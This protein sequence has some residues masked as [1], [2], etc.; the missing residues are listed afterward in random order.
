MAETSVSIV[1]GDEAIKGLRAVGSRTVRQKLALKVDDLSKANAPEQIGKPLQDEL[2]GLFRITFGRYRTI[3]S[4]RRSPTARALE[5]IVQV[6]LVGIRK[7]G[8]K[9]DVYRVAQRLHR[10]GKL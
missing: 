4:V 7:E 9:T 1:W 2:Q 5:I 3:Y 6:I 10:Q 8:H